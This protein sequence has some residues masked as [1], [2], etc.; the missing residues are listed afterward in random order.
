MRLRFGWPQ[1]IA[2]PSF[3]AITATLVAVVATNFSSPAAEAATEFEVSY[4]RYGLPSDGVKFDYDETD[5]A[6]IQ[7]HQ[8]VK[9]SI[10]AAIQSI[11]S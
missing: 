2:P 4:V 11:E 3:A 6:A 10:E 1:L 8:P 5:P 9:R 7:A